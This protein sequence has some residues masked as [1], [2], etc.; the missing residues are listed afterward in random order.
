MSKL[1]EVNPIDFYH[2]INQNTEKKIETEKKVETEE[3]KQTKEGENKMTK[4]EKLEKENAKL[5]KE[6]K[7]LKEQPAKSTLSPE[8]EEVK[9][10]IKINV[11]SK[12]VDVIM[13]LKSKK[14]G[15]KFYGSIRKAGHRVN[16][17][18]Y[19]NNQ[20]RF[21]RNLSLSRKAYLNLTSFIEKYAKEV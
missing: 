7:K 12:H 9:N 15:T 8:V 3:V 10:G 17:E 20:I 19:D 13:I 21:A 6:N 5:K 14:A 4:L 1:S 16:F 18:I 2:E 11:S